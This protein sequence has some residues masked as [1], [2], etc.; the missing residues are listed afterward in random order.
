MGILSLLDEECWFPKATDKTYVEKLHKE[1]LKNAK[2]KKPDF[3]S[4]A[5][6]SIVHYAGTVSYT[7]N[8]VLKYDFV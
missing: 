5:S 1:H 3:R 6:F 4:A 8:P 2:Y 7:H